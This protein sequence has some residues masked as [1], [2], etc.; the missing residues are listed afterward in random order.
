LL[1][2]DL[3]KK[4]PAKKLKGAERKRYIS[5]PIGAPVFVCPVTD[6]GDT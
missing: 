3:D 2:N 4:P 6:T 5:D 1:A